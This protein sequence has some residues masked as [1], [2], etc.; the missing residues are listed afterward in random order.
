MTFLE[1]NCPQPIY[2]QIKDA[3]VNLI[4]RTPLQANEPIPSERDLCERFGV[5]RLT[6]RKAID[7][8][9]QDGVLFRQPGKGTFVSPPKITQPL[10]VLRSFTEAMLQEG[11][12]PGTRV[13]SIELQASSPKIC[14][15]LQIAVGMPV[16]K[17]VRVRY[18]DNLPLSLV[19]SYLPRDLVPKLELSDI[20]AVSLYSLLR[21]KCGLHLVRSSV[22]LE[23][24]VA[25]YWEAA[26][27][28]IQIGLPMML[29]RGLVFTE[30]S[31]V[32]EYC[33]ALYRGDKVRFAAESG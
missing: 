20:G 10:L 8:L 25:R 16:I 11:Y 9:V 17:L 3:I 1:R 33:V 12:V 28:N 7:E 18:I 26:L 5:N 30:N 19:T 22:T 6:V 14:Q 21:E 4:D 31:R 2:E 24:T 32:L 29:L 23:P 27:L 15:K 13:H